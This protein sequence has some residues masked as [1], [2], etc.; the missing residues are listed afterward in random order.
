MIYILIKID[1]CINKEKTMTNPNIPTKEI[2]EMIGSLNRNP[3]ETEIRA[4]TD[5]F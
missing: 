3:D 2:R 4:V 1:I 5:Y